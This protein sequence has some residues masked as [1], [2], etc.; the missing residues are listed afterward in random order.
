MELVDVG[1]SKSPGSDTVSVR[2]RPEALRDDS[3]FCWVVF[4][5]ESI[6][7]AMPYMVDTI[8]LTKG[9]N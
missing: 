8:E 2:V 1:D 5:F 7:I 9:E 3:A 4:F 6:S